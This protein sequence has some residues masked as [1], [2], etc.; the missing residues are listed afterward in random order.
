MHT[1]RNAKHK[2]HKHSR[3]YFK[4]ITCTVKMVM[5]NTRP[6][7]N[8]FG[9][10]CKS[11][12]V[13]LFLRILLII[14]NRQLLLIKLLFDYKAKWKRYDINFYRCYDNKLSFL[15]MRQAARRIFIILFMVLLFTNK[16]F[17]KMSHFW[18]HYTLLSVM[19]KTQ[20]SSTCACKFN[21]NGGSRQKLNSQTEG[22]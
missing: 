7:M 10:Q 1:A 5:I 13:A 14:Y 20:A 17:T 16:L 11:Q 6:R 4:A 22:C 15:K 21:N 2:Y 12:T 18:G 8:L 3:L 9:V 19:F